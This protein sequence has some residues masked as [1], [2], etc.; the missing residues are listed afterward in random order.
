[1]ASVED[2]RPSETPGSGGPEARWP[3]SHPAEEM[4]VAADRRHA[5]YDEE[6]LEAAL[7]FLVLRFAAMATRKD[8]SSGRVVL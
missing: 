8:S 6:V 2:D 3:G 4:V 7:H 5:G 1:M